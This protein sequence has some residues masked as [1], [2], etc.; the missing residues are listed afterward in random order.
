[1]PFSEGA[2]KI[3]QSAVFFIALAEIVRHGMMV[4]LY[5]RGWHG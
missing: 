4:Y 2:V 1:M 3:F 5:Q